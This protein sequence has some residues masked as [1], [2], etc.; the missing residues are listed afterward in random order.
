MNSQKSL[1]GYHYTTLYKLVGITIF[2]CSK[3]K[4]D[5]RKTIIFAF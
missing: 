4:P 1:V 3:Q 2:R 5:T